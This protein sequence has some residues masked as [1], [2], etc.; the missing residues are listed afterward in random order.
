MSEQNPEPIPDP[1]SPAGASSS[2][3][4]PPEATSG[5]QPANAPPGQPPAGEYRDW[6]EQRRAERWARRQQRWERRGARPYGWIGGAVLILLGVA[7]LLQNMGFP[8][9]ENWWALF[10]LLPALGAF[11]A[12]WES[13]QDQSRLT[14][15]GMI[16]LSGGLLLTLLA[17]AFLFGLDVGLFW[18]VLLIMGGL[19]LLVSALLPG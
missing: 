12:A 3:G 18:P 11:G 8:F 14:R 6:R 16:S 2:A 1:N 15:G 5:G 4:N 10:I 19:V 13:Y 9:L 7:F 17:F